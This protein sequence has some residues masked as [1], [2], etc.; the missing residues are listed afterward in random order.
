MAHLAVVQEEEGV[1]EVVVGVV[2]GE[3]GRRWPATRAG[4][5]TTR[6]NARWAPAVE[7]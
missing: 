6:A 1:E 4:A 7:A 5:H 2:V 3:A